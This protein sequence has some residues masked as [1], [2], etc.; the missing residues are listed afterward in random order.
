MKVS[1]II[2]NWNGLDH[3]KD[4]L[5]SIE[6]QSYRDYE[7]II[8]D[9][10]SIDEGIDYVEKNFPQYKII[11]N[12]KNLGFPK[13]NNQ[14]IHIAKGEYIL[15]LNNDTELDRD[16]LKNYVEFAEQ[17][18]KDVG[19]FS[20]KMLFFNRRNGI[21]S[22]GLNLY[23][24]GSS[25]DEAFNEIDKGFNSSKEV[26]G[27]CGGAALFKKE[28]LEDI[29]IEDDY[30]DS[31][32]FL[33]AED[34]D[35]AFRLQL[36]GWK[37]QYVPNAKVYH[38]VN[39]TTKK[40]P[41]VGVYHGHKNKIFLILKNYPTSLLIKKSPKIILRQF[42]SIFYYLTKFNLTPI[43][44]R[45]AVIKLL[46]KMLKKRRIIQKSRTLSSKEVESLL[47]SKKFFM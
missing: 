30:L 8:V 19:M 10:G 45:I 43:K 47:K 42:I 13:P 26:F 34:T 28:A 17:S 38:K 12:N 15:L 27:P 4:C 46:P 11:K 33:Y 41:N 22:I 20:C 35:L 16:F 14:G 3:L 40:I 37:C 32:F 2:V 21:N 44:S 9:N 6:K 7:V 18:E 39:A 36:R 24:D 23:D 5:P 25:I 29:K 31:D 1:I